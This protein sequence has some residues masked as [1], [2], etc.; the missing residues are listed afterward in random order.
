M[1]ALLYGWETNN[2]ALLSESVTTSGWVAYQAQLEYVK[3]DDAMKRAAV[4]PDADALADLGLRLEILRSR[5]PLL[6]ASEDGRMLPEIDALAPMLQRFE[7]VLDGMID[8][9]PALEQSVAPKEPVLKAWSAALS[10]LG[11]D[12][13]SVLMA[14]VAYNDALFARERSLAGQTT[15][16]PLGL[17]FLSGSALVS[18]MWL[19]G[20]RDR[21]RLLEVETARR[22]VCEME[23]NLLGVIQAAP[24]AMLV[25]DPLERAVRFINP[26]AAEMVHPS[27][28]HP[29][30]KRLIDT[31]LEEVQIGDDG[32]MV[33]RIAF[34]KSGGDVVSLKG[35]LSP[36][37][38]EG[39]PQMLMVLIDNTR[40]RDADLQLIQAAKLATLGEMAT[41]IAHELNQPLA[42]IRMAVANA[43]RHLGAEDA[44]DAVAAKLD[45]VT[46]Q[47]NRAKRIID[48][49][50]RYGRQ[51]SGKAA[52]FP[53]RPTLELAAGFVAE[54]YRACGI[55]LAL[56]LDV[57]GDLSIV[58][59]R[60]L[61]E[62]VIVNLLIN[63]RDAFEL[64]ALARPRTVWLRARVLDQKVLV[65]VEDMAGG[66]S[67]EVMA[68]LFEPFSTTKP[69]GAGAGLGLSLARSV[70]RDMNGHI[71]A[72]NMRNGACFTLLLPITGPP[73]AR[74]AA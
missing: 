52:S 23:R 51:P 65:E 12:L 53:L 25:L 37:M 59:D 70:V 19:R 62:H 67:E 58:G 66:I 72:E 6:H 13:Q 15:L 16:L 30:W 74:E 8:A 4:R 5:L 20:R 48:Q 36:V 39:R 1:T 56:Q 33:V 42:V 10:P 44:R 60:D 14:S 57:P 41:A 49:V 68:H 55:R 17:L 61:L 54:Q 69:A 26:A 9:L 43:H 73:A 28:G 35:S 21:E 50:R 63:A 47:V 7:T 11:R 71:V 46:L 31:S 38:W 3:A 32:G 18:L 27:P 45:R 40:T 2:R 22:A 24:T 29:D 64:R 34:T